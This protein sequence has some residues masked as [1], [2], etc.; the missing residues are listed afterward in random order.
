M[1]MITSSNASKKKFKQSRNSA[2][3]L[4]SLSIGTSCA[5]RKAKIIFMWVAAAAPT[6]WWLTCFASPTWIPSIS[7]YISSGSSIRI[8]PVRPTLI[9]TSAGRTATTLPPKNFPLTQFSMLEAED[10]GLYKFDILSQHGLGK[11]KDAVNIV[12]QNKHIE[13]DIHNIKRFK[14]DEEVRKKLQVADLM[15]AFYV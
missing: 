14:E 10:V 6:A 13:I 4:T 2:T 1:L 12:R 8:A 15:G 9:L 3:L 11:I 7:I 5:M